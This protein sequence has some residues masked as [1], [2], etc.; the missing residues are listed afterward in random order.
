MGINVGGDDE[1]INELVAMI[2]RLMEKGGGHLTIDADERADGIKVRTYS[3][4]DCGASGKS[5]ACCQP[6][7]DAVDRK[8]ED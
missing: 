5:S 6:T 1:E 2:D 7:E 3:T 8:D 4:S